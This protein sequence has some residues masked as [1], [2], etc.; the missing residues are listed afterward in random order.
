MKVRIL[1][2]VAALALGAAIGGGAAHAAT[3]MLTTSDAFGSGDFGE[4]TVTGTS[5]DLHFDVQM[6]GSYQIIDTGSHF[7][8]TGDVAG[9]ISSLSLTPSEYY[10]TGHPATSQPD[11][12]LTTGS[13]ANSNPPFSG[14]D[15]GLNCQSCGNGSNS[16]FGQHLVFDLIGTGLSVKQAS[17]YNNTPIYFAADV[18]D[19]DG[20]TGVVGGGGAIPEP[21]AWGLMIMGVFG[22][23]AVMRHKRRRALSAA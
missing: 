23:G 15:F 11:F 19:A 7:G 12:T 5:T 14:F 22:I 21:A 10:T 1:A 6:F 9:T 17:T 13:A 4:V 18:T 3:Y 2:A 20:N 8:F 16:P